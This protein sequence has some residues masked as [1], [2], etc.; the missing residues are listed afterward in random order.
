MPTISACA[1][2]RLA[3]Y[4]PGDIR[5]Y[6]PIYILP[7]PLMTHLHHSMTP[8]ATTLQQ[9]G[10]PRFTRITRFAHIFGFLILA[11]DAGLG[12]DDSEGLAVIVFTTMGAPDRI[13]AGAE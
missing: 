6:G 1:V 4:F 11:A 10:Y 5:R 13:D 7:N 12:I 3:S 2:R 9:T 8:T